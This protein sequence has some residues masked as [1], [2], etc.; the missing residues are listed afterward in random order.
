MLLLVKFGE[1]FGNKGTG[2][3]AGAGREKPLEFGGRVLESVK[4]KKG[5]SPGFKSRT[6][7]FSFF[8]SVIF[9][10]NM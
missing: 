1:A 9:V 2:D 3:R 8:F 7:F 4:I 6:V 10:H 5:Y